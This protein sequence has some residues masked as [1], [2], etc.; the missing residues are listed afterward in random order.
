[1]RCCAGAKR[2]VLKRREWEHFRSWLSDSFHSSVVVVE[3]EERFLVCKMEEEPWG[4]GRCTWKDRPSLVHFDGA[5]VVRST[6]LEE[7]HHTVVDRVLS[8]H[9]YLHYDS[10]GFH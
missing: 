9:R 8:R 1:V 2:A 10:H 4:K 7:E 5:V 6:V 3:E